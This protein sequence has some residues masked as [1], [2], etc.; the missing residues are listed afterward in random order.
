[1]NNKLFFSVIV[2][3]HVLFVFLHIHTYSR[4]IKQSYIKQKIDQKKADLEQ[5][6]QLLTQQMYAFKNQNAIKEFA[7]NK[8]NLQPIS[9]KQIRKLS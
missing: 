5:K 1:M 7:H 4:I 3:A 8:L 9:L 2:C 6:K